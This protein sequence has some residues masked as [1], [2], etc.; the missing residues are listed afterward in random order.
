VSNQSHLALVAELREKPDE[1]EEQRVT[2]QDAS[3]QDH[4]SLQPPT[5]IEAVMSI[6]ELLDGAEMRHAELE[7]Q[8]LLTRGLLG[9]L[10]RV[11]YEEYMDG[12]RAY[13]RDD[14]PGYEWTK[15]SRWLDD[16]RSL[17]S[18][19]APFPRPSNGFNG[20]SGSPVHRERRARVL[21]AL[22]LS[23]A[24]CAFAQLCRRRAAA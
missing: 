13:A 24:L 14:A 3:G 1:A 6:R 9:E 21:R 12:G 22:A 8:Y 10:V 23:A 16:H 15:V 11:A 7:A 5:H 17:L 20:A 19:G 4:V 2:A 18:P